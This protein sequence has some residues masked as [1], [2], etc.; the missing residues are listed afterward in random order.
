MTSG[1]HP[2]IPGIPCQIPARLAGAAGSGQNAGI[3]DRSGRLAEIL[4]GF[5]SDLARTTRPPASSRIRP[6]RPR[7]SQNGEIPA[8][9]AGFRST[10]RDPAALCRIP[11]KIAGIRQKW[12]DSSN[13]CRNLYLLNMK[14][15]IFLY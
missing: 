13:F 15:K 5:G 8:R 14:K 2:R 11:A 9:T 12:S 6:V 1:R 7:S 3:L 10:G 4:A